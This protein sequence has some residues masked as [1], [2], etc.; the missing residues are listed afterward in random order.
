MKRILSFVILLLFFSTIVI[1]KDFQIT[2]PDGKI[3]AS[4]SIDK[5]IMYSVHFGDI[6]VIE[7][8]SVSFI[9]KQAPPLGKNMEVLSDKN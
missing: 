6:S 5:E 9:F 8:S 2:S 1:G 7:P 3:K 4:V